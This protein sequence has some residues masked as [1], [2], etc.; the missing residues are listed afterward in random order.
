VNPF[1]IGTSAPWLIDLDRVSAVGPVEPLAPSA[2][3]ITCLR[4]VVDGQMVEICEP[5][6][7]QD[8]VHQRGRLLV[9]L[10]GVARMGLS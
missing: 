9:A 5:V 6:N 10:E 3:G 8:M 7:R 2:S 4:L 1:V